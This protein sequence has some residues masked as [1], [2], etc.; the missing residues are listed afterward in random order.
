MQVDT[1]NKECFY[2]QTAMDT[3]C[4]FG[5]NDRIAWSQ[6]E[7]R[8]RKRRGEGEHGSESGQAERWPGWGRGE[9]GTVALCVWMWPKEEVEQQRR[10]GV[11]WLSHCSQHLLLGQ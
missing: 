9:A 7:T 10:A 1:P 11:A 3:V 5:A 2:L 4:V 8:W 6:R